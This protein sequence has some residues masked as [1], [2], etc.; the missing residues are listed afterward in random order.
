[1][2]PR[3]AAIVGATGLVGGHILDT[4]LSDA[5]H[6]RVVALVRRRVLAEHPSLVQVEVDFRR[7]DLV[8]EA[9]TDLYCCLG[10]TIRKAGSRDAFREVDLQFPL[11]FARWGMARGA[12]R[13]MLVSSVDAGNKSNFYLRTKGELETTLAGVGFEALHIFQP[14]FLTGARAETRVG[15]RIGIAIASV[16]SPLLVGRFRKY[17][18]M[19]AD[20]LARAM[21]A[22]AWSGAGGVRRYEFDSIQG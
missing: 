8:D 11:N 9:A 17:R 4:L 19:P 13:F 15:E 21:V 2:Q 1:M 16:V 14:S 7:L 10:T 5:R 18:P 12:K 20:R 6:S 22:A 3:T